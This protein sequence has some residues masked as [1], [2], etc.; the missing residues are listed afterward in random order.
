MEKTVPFSKK[1]EETGIGYVEENK[2]ASA[3]IDQSEKFIDDYGQ[4]RDNILHLSNWIANAASNIM[5]RSL[6]GTDGQNFRE[7]EIVSQIGC[8]E[9]FLRRLRS[10]VSNKLVYKQFLTNESCEIAYSYSI[11]DIGLDIISKSHKFYS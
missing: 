9:K 7:S 2:T 5:P 11:C 6:V 8:P 1:V 4:E 10:E 3:L